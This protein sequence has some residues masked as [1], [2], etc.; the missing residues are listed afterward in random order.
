MRRKGK[1]IERKNRLSGQVR[2]SRQIQH[3]VG[4]PPPRPT[5]RRVHLIPGYQLAPAAILIPT[6]DHKPPG[7]H[8]QHLDIAAVVLPNKHLLTAHYPL[9]TVHSF[10]AT[11]VGPA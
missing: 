8:R 11:S 1:P 2:A 9:F 6:P 10:T 3:G 5:P 7:R 4:D